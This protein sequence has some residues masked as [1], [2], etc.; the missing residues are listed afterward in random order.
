MGF[1]FSKY[2][3]SLMSVAILTML[4]GGCDAPSKT[5]TPPTVF[6]DMVLQNGVVATVDEAIG[7]V[8][9]IAVAGHEI[10]AVGSNEEISAY[11]NADTQVIDLAGRMATPGF[12][13][14]HGHFMSLGR[15]KQIL[16]LTNITNW[17]Q[18]VSR[19]AAAVDSAEPG[20]WIFGRG[21]HQDKWEQIPEDAIDGVPLNTTLNLISP[22]NPVLLGHASGHAAFAN[23]AALRAAGITDA[24]ADPEGGTIVRAE[25]GRATGLLRETAQR[26][27][28]SVGAEYESQ[29]S[30]EEVERLKREQVFLASSEALANGVTSFQDAGADFATIDFF[31]QLESEGALPIR[32]YVMVRGE[33]NA[34]MEKLLPA[35]LMPAEENDFLTVRSIKRQLDGALGAHGAWLLEPY[36]DLPSTSGLV[37][38]SVEDI[39][40]TARLAMKYGYQVNTHAIGDR[41]NR[42]TLDLYQRAFTTALNTVEEP[43]ANLSQDSVQDLRWRVEHAQHIDPADVPRFGELGV[44]A[45]IQGVHCTSDG[46]WVPSRLGEER[47]KLTSYPWRDLIDTGAIV[48]NGTDVPVEAIDPIASFYASVSRMTKSGE[49]FHPEQAMTRAEALASY[50][51]NNAYAAF[52]E[53]HKG[54]LTPGKLADIVVLSQNILSVDEAQIANTEVDMTIVAGKVRYA[55]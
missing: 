15:A 19:V 6:A 47:T 26:L 30:D 10:I 36:V 27:V 7:N 35:Y 42:E 23:D 1:L 21:W 14:G 8:Q 5:Q 43:D 24:T 2:F 12:I 18:A 40:E 20:E 54:S 39:E 48:A 11:I 28:A 4:L 29:R 46:P 45:A 53:A 22:N 44:I 55:R 34:Q 50:T 25:N 38:E 52:E 41:A 13:E 9:A 31:K 51:I 49:K 37:L 17:Q 33:S 32:L 3:F 16:D